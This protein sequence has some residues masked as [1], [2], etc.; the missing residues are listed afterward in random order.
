MLKKNAAISNWQHA[1]LALGV[2]LSLMGAFLMFHGSILG[3]RTTGIATLIG[4]LGT[5]TI[6]M[7]RARKR[8]EKKQSTGG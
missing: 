1:I 5:G 7:S 8:M 6:A 4:I 2:S 3:E